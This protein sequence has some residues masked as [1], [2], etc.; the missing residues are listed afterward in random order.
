MVKI[1]RFVELIQSV[2]VTA[3]STKNHWRAFLGE[4]IGVDAGWP[5]I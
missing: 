3:I 4:T 2:P 1:K 5:A